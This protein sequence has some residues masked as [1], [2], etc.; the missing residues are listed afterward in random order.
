M[1]AFATLSIIM[2]VL[3]FLTG[4]SPTGH[5][6]LEGTLLE[7]SNENATE[8]AFKLTD[9]QKFDLVI[10]VLKLKT[11]NKED[12]KLQYAEKIAKI[13]KLVHSSANEDVS[14]GWTSLA[15]C[16]DKD[17][18]TDEF[19]IFLKTV[20]IAGNM[21]EE[22]SWFGMKKDDATLEK[23]LEN[24]LELKLAAE[25]NNIVIRSKLV[26]ETN[27]IIINHSSL[28]AKEQWETLVNCNFACEGFDK[29]LLVVAESY[30]ER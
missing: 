29:L 20:F 23:L 22:S 2:L 9:R 27:S 11:L 15:A 19:Y 30:F 10:A 24:L 13:D 6:I 4:S 17:S 21:K 12:R 16:L 1:T 18:C 8:D 28:E 5:S 25:K 26:T 3:Y 7:K 14:S